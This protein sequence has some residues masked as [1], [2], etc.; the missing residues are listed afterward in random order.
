M[1]SPS[2]C[3]APARPLPFPTPSAHLECAPSTY[4][5]LTG[6]VASLLRLA[7]FV[8]RGPLR[9]RLLNEGLGLSRALMD[10]TIVLE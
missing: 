4:Q 9:E 1:S 6:R 3:A 5:A 10:I 8:R 2:T 7:G